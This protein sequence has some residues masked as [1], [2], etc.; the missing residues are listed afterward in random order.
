MRDAITDQER[1]ALVKQLEAGVPWSQVRQS[2]TG[3][4]PV[5][6]DKGFK[7]WAMKKACVEEKPAP[8]PAKAPGKKNDPLE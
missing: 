8:A 1:Y 2:L 7:E 4:D 3:V 6:L 5:A